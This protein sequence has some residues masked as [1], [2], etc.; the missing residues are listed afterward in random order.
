LHAFALRDGAAERADFVA[1]L[2]ILV[3][4]VLGVPH[5]QGRVLLWHGGGVGRVDADGG[6]AHGAAFT[7]VAGREADSKAASARAMVCQASSTEVTRVASS[8]TAWRCRLLMVPMKAW[9]NH[10]P[11]SGTCCQ[12][13]LVPWPL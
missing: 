3:E 4:P 10:F 6:G 5:R 11:E 12:L 9:G 7:A 13:S 2:E 8:P 1:D